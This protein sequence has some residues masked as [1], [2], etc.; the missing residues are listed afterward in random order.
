MVVYWVSS[1]TVIMKK[2]KKVQFDDSK[3]FVVRFR[4]YWRPLEGF[5]FHWRGFK[6]CL[7]QL[8]LYAG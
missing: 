8:K 6:K 1:K 3:K 5:Y 4:F 7:L 2:G